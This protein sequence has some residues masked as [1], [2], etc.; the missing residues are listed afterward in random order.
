M[1][2]LGRWLLPAYA[3]LVFV[4][5][6]LAAV[7]LSQST[8]LPGLSAIELILLSL[9]WSFALGVE[10]LSRVGS[11]GMALMVF[12]G[13]GLNALVIRWVAGRLVLWNGV[14]TKG[15]RPP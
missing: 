1:R 4:A 3:L 6:L 8:E 9:P 15:H 13:L 12:A 7:R 5:L 14:G 2:L 11:V 10:P